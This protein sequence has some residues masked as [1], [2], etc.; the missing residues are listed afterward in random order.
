MQ[1]MKMEIKECLRANLE[2]G[3][4]SWLSQSGFARRK[5]TLVYSRTF[6]AAVQHIRLYIE[7]HPKDRPDS[8][9]AL[10]PWLDVSIDAVNKQVIE[11]IGG[12][13]SLLPGLPDNTL[14]EPIEFTSAKAEH[15]R[16]FIF[17]PDSVPGVV[18]EMKSFLQKWTLPFLDAY[19]TTQGICEAYVRGDA[20]VLSDVAQKLRVAA[21]MKLCG[22]NDDAVGAM[23]K[24]FGRPGPRKQ[25]QRVFD[26]LEGNS[27]VGQIHRT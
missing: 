4:D 10:Y 25:Y 5:N 2:R 7:I 18:G 20:R 26:Y 27:S 17:Q 6:S 9:A 23:E 13:L 21:A 8:A 22:R 3:L 19:S 24:W 11:M 14:K 15:A 1:S 12:D 16:W